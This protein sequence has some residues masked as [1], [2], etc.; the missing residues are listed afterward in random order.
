MSTRTAEPTF[1]HL[2]AALA[3]VEAQ[4]PPE[5]VDRLWLFAPRRSG[6]RESGFA[7]LALYGA[8]ARHR[9]VYTLRYEIPAPQDGERRDA[10]H[11]E[12]SV[13]GERV[14]RIIAGVT[15]RTGELQDPREVC[16]GGELE[17]W[18]ALVQGDDG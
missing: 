6:A 8:D 13:P 9:E 16:I 14:A 10:L 3:G 11:A 2:R 17:R 1:V 12:G 18:R 4:L 15:R 5:R 7:V